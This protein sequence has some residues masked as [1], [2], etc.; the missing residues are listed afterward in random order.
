MM[1]TIITG[2]IRIEATTIAIVPD[3]IPSR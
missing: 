2:I 1:A 3:R